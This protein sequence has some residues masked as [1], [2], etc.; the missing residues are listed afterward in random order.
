MKVKASTLS[1][2]GGSF[3]GDGVVALEVLSELNEAPKAKGGARTKMV[4]IL[5]VSY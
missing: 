4:L 1:S 2:G 3:S 5:V